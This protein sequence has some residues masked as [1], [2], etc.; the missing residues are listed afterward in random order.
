MSHKQPLWDAFTQVFATSNEQGR[1]ELI[2]RILTDHPEP[3]RYMARQLLFQFALP[4]DCADD[5]AQIVRLETY[6]YLMKPLK[7]GFTPS[8]TMGCIKLAARAEVQRFRQSSAYTGISGQV[9]ARRRQSALEQHRLAM[10]RTLGYSPE[11]QELVDSYNQ[12]L[13]E[14]RGQA[15]AQRAGA[16]ATVDDLR[17]SEVYTHV[18]HDGVSEIET[19]VDP[20]DV[21]DAASSSAA[22]AAI[23]CTTIARASAVDETLGLVATIVLGSNVADATGDIDLAPASVVAATGLPRRDVSRLLQE[24]KGILIE[25]IDEWGLREP[26]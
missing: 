2:G 25:V 3:F 13:F 26:A 7:P 15:E 19:V 18:S 17:V 11:D 1:S 10:I 9:T 12:A 8:A 16:T 6:R 22:V 23:S 24:L 20:T 21:A 14:R 5:V 4:S